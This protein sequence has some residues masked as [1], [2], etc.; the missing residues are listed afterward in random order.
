MKTVW[1][2]GTSSNLSGMPATTPIGINVWPSNDPR[3]YGRYRDRVK[4]DYTRWFNLH[5]RMWMSVKYPKSLRWHMEQD[6]SRP[7]YTQKRWKDI[8]GSV[9]FP[10]HAIQ[11]R[12]RTAT[13]LNRYFTCSVCWLIAL[14]MLE[15]FERIELY[16]FMFDNKPGAMYA[17]QRPCF[18][19]WV[20]EA[21]RRGIEVVLQPGVRKLPPIAGDPDTYDGPLYGFQT[22]PEGQSREEIRRSLSRPRRV[23]EAT[24]GV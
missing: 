3:K 19:Y 7:F 9:K 1:I 16:G 21:R 14:A 10:R 2:L 12:F 18:F 22:K 23:E 24:S 6:G 20:Y 8:P 4:R 15:K 17:H 13:G 11:K 5:S